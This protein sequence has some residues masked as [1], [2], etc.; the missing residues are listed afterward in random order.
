MA[1]EPAHSGAQRRVPFEAVQLLRHGI[2]DDHERLLAGR[3]AAAEQSLPRKSLCKRH[4]MGF[5]AQ[6]R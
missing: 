5:G 6:V 2:G 1:P 4:S 3:E